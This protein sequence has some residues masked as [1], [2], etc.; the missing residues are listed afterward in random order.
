MHYLRHCSPE[1][2]AWDNWTDPKMHGAFMLHKM[3]NGP[4]LRDLPLNGRRPYLRPITGQSAV[5]EGDL[6]KAARH[7]LGQARDLIASYMTYTNEHAMDWRATGDMPDPKKYAT[8]SDWAFLVGPVF[9]RLDLWGLLPFVYAQLPLPLLQIMPA[10]VGETLRNSWDREEGVPL[11]NVAKYHTA[12]MHRIEIMEDSGVDLGRVILSEDP[13]IK[14]LSFAYKRARKRHFKPGDAVPEDYDGAAWR[15][16]GHQ[17]QI[18]SGLL[19]LS[20]PQWKKRLR[21]ANADSEL[22]YMETKRL[23][24]DA[25]GTQLMYP[26]IEYYLEQNEPHRPKHDELVKRYERFRLARKQ[27]AR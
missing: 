24:A 6:S 14:A 13:G 11:R 15:G 8:L 22:A 7:D 10:V 5:S 1:H 23:Q 19:F 9:W 18:A 25:A 20:E 17:S 21:Q 2:R 3:D 26:S 12:C 16:S 4:T 27:Q